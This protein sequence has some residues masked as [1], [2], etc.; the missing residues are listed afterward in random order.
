MDADWDALE[1]LVEACHVET[2]IVDL[3]HQHDHYSY[4]KP[5]REPG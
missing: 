1:A 5:K 4:G 3:A 2:G